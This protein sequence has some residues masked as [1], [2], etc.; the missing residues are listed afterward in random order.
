MQSRHRVLNCGRTRLRAPCE[1]MRARAKKEAAPVSGR[2]QSGHSSSLLGFESV[3][4]DAIGHAAAAAALDHD[5]SMYQPS[6][7]LAL[8]LPSRKRNCASCPAYVDR[9]T[10]TDRTPTQGRTRPG[11]RP[12]DCRCRS[13][14]CRCSRPATGRRHLVEH[15]AVDRDFEDAAV[16]AGRAAPSIRRHCS[17]WKLRPPRSRGQR[18]HGR[19]QALI[20]D[21][22]RIGRLPGR[23]AGKRTAAGDRPGIGADRCGVRPAVGA[24]FARRR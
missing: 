11:C 18:D 14:P 8:L 4:E 10:M 13:P 12:A 16:G 5:S 21:R 17:N 2:G 9:S 15:A 23:A 20:G 24:G 19:G 7:G 3:G 6:R 1:R 22:R